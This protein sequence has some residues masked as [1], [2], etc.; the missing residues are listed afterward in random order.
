MQLALEASM[1]AAEAGSV[2]LP[3]PPM[4]PVTPHGFRTLKDARDSL[5]DILGDEHLTIRR[6]GK[7]ARGSSQSNQKNPTMERFNQWSVSLTSLLGKVDADNC[8]PTPAILVLRI[9][10]KIVRIMLE[11]TR[12]NDEC[13]FDCYGREFSE[14]IELAT[15]LHA[16]KTGTFSVDTSLNPALFYAAIKC[17][18]PTIR[19]RAIGLLIG[20]PR[21]DRLQDSPLAVRLASHIVEQEEIAA[22][23]IV[24]SESDVS[25]AARMNV[26]LCTWEESQDKE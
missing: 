19:R 16:L 24:R 18:E 11:N 12:K 21:Q 17:R 4:E 10:H 20:L 8:D 13:V 3:P 9:W 2:P 14:A 5:Y 6:L 1:L 7:Q 23:C 22:G 25:R 26:K 15:T